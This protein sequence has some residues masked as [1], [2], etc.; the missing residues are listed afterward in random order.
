M[1]SEARTSVNVVLPGSRKLYVLASVIY[2]LSAISAISNLRP[3]AGP[4]PHHLIWHWTVWVDI[5]A[6]AWCIYLF[7]EMFSATSSRI[8]EVICV[9]TMI[10]FALG[11]PQSLHRLGYRWAEIPGGRWIDLVLVI[12]AACLVFLRTFQVFNRHEDMGR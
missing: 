11:I 1:A 10:W 7:F 4:H 6:E 9:L 12:V 3:S 8:E 5:W 2:G